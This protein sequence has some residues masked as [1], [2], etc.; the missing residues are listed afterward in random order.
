MSALG[1]K[2]SLLEFFQQ[3]YQYDEGYV[4]IGITRPPAKRDTFSE[5]FFKWPSERNDLIDYIERVRPNH[6]VYFCVNVLSVP[7]RKKNNA[8]PQNLVWAD[9]DTCHP[10]NLEIP[11]QV[12]IESSPNRYQAIWRIDQKVDPF[13]AENYSKRIAYAYADQGADKTGH[14]L[15][16]LLRVP[17]TYNFKY[18]MADTPVVQLVANIDD[19]IA[20]EVF[21]GLPVAE[22]GEQDL[23]DIDVPDLLTLPSYDMIVYRYTD[24]LVQ[25]GMMNAYARYVGDEPREDW[26]GQL[27]NLILLCFEAGMTANEVFVVA[28]NAKCNKY[29]RDG[30]PD[31]HLWREVLKAE[32]ERKTVEVLLREHRH[33]QMPALL[34]AEEQEQVPTT[35]IDNYVDWATDVTDAVEEFHELTCAT[36]MSALM[37]TTLRLRTSRAQTIVPNLWALIFG[38]ST[39]TRKTTAMSMGMDFLMDIDPDLI[40]ASDASM[41]G[42]ITNLSLRP[43]MVSIFYRDEITGFFQSVQQKEYLAGMQEMLTQMYDVP[44]FLKRTLKKDTYV[45]TEPIFIMFGGGI[46]S[47][48]YSLIDDFS[49][50]SGFMPR[51]LILNGAT[52]IDNIRPLG[53][54][55]AVHMDKRA[56]IAAT[57][58]AYYAMYTNAQVSVELGD[59]QKMLMAPEF[60]VEFTPEMWAKAAQ[61]EQTLVRTAADSPEKEKAL[62]TFSRMYISLLKL[63]MLFAGARQEPEDNTVHAEMGDMLAAAR[64]I[65]RWGRHSVDLIRNSGHNADEAKLQACYRSVKQQPGIMRS[66]I[67]QRH[68]L[69]A[70]EMENV[71]QTLMQRQLIEVIKKGTKF[72]TYWP[73]GR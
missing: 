17:G 4:C 1:E 50:I 48:A 14:D 61:M 12:V 3:L 64:Y 67:M 28:K 66:E 11:P 6:N 65:E 7:R 23:P 59:G 52:D 73:I 36:I 31:S 46:A 39:L 35:L 47:R 68:R 42:L 62:P 57:F 45:V 33:L 34:T 55:V 8:I 22:F 20:K 70:R 15:T 49:Y 24:T 72:R 16:Q 43:K 18:Q 41:E 29:E 51:F 60:E 69:N 27:W 54:P 2:T 10:R 37:S 30:R 44:K 19:V 63:T 58:Q 13:I 25:T 56:D 38:E 71:E 40:V 32:L 9:L 53:P 26:S 5:Q 21:D